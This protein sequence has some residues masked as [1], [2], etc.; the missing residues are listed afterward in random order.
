MKSTKIGILSIFVL[1]ITFS[2][3]IIIQ[4]TFG[5]D[6]EEAK[7]ENS[8]NIAEGS[9][10]KN[11]EFFANDFSQQKVLFLVGSSHVGHIN[12]TEVNKIIAK[13]DPI[14]IYN[15]A[16]ASDTPKERLSQL[17]EIIKTKPKMV[18]Y[19]ISYRDFSFPSDLVLVP[20]FPDPKEIISCTI[21]LKIDEIVPSNPQFLTREIINEFLSNQTKN[22][23]EQEQKYFVMKNTPF[24]PYQKNPIIAT[25]NI[26][27]E[28]VHFAPT[29]ND[30]NITYQ[31]ICALDSII[32]Q[33]HSSGIKIILF[34]SPL[35]K[36][37]LE[38]LSDSQKNQFSQLQKEIT[39]KHKITIY[40]FEEKYNGL[41]IWDDSS[42]I[43]NHKNVTIFNEEIAKMIIKEYEE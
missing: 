43:S 39:T 26:L 12:V 16:K 6:L 24:I 10:L 2:A 25:D 23:F 11:D 1:I 18:F 17:E 14:T 9:I 31:N 15:I 20:I 38:S 5:K 3:L 36:Y 21:S 22:N 40:D 13:N 41:N 28:N 27:K 35:H 29:W 19:G 7:R 30:Q 42:H 32:S 8:I 34:T 33:L 37:Y 4:Q